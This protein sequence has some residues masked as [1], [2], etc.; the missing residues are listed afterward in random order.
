MELKDFIQTGLDRA[1]DATVKAV[2]GLSHY[3]LMWRPGPEAN[4]IGLILFHQARSEDSY[5]HTRIQGKPQIWES[6]KW[7]QKLS[8]PVTET[9]SGY[10]AE[11]LHAFPV[12]ELKELLAYADA[13]R[14]STLVYLK[15]AAPND[16]D[17]IINVPRQG[18]VTVGSYLARSLGHQ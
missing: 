7:Y 4:S 10:T 5:L 1:K 8:L 3:E 15:D 14:A 18:D 12:P 9:G 17:R 16:F 11:Q 13:V 6:E 2:D